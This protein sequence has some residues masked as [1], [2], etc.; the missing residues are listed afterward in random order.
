[1]QKERNLEEDSADVKSTVKSSPPVL[2]RELPQRAARTAGGE[3]IHEQYQL[4]G[5]WKKHGVDRSS[6]DKDSKDRSDRELSISL[7]PGDGPSTPLKR[8][9]YS[10][11]A[12]GFIDRERSAEHDQVADAWPSSRAVHTAL[13]DDNSITT[14][15]FSDKNSISAISPSIQH[16]GRVVRF[17]EF[18]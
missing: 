6:K 3:R 10:D 18:Q 13:H 12:T 16:Q 14:T 7:E 5:S 1:M 15:I 2:T 11:A 4:K 8:R 9:K 17:Q